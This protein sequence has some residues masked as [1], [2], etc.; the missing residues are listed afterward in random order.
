M[1]FDPHTGQ[2]IFKGSVKP[3]D[4]TKPGTHPLSNVIG[5]VTGQ[6]PMRIEAAV[7]KGFSPYNPYIAAAGAGLRQLMGDTD[8]RTQAQTSEYILAKHLRP[9]IKLT[10]PISSFV[11]SIEERVEEQGSYRKQQNDMLDKMVFQVQHGKGSMRDVQNYIM[12]QPPGASTPDHPEGVDRARMKQYATINYNVDSVM[13]EYGAGNITGVPPK[14]WW[15]I[16]NSTSAKV[17]AQEF[18]SKWISA[19]DAGRKRM[20]NI[21]GMLQAKKTGYM[22]DEFKRELMR[23]RSMLGTDRR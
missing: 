16:T 21:A 22:S 12:S 11:D 8:Y 15:I 2:K 4:E 19:D 23:E 20:E 9:I 13:K 1:N 7:G 10:N 17:R 18:H 3:E 14:T 6:S 5:Q